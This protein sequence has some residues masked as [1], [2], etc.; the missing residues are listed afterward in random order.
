MLAIRSPVLPRVLRFAGNGSLLSSPVLS[1]SSKVARA[2]G[3][4]YGYADLALHTERPLP[5]VTSSRPSEDASPPTVTSSG[6][7][8]FFLPCS[9]VD[10]H[11]L[12]I[13]SPVIGNGDEL[14]GKVEGGGTVRACVREKGRRGVANRAGG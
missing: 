13:S 1:G 12:S 10:I 4:G 3:E 9:A 11:G 8:F 2:F 6:Y 14:T 5:A 7:P